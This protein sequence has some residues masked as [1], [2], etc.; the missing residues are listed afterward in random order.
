MLRPRKIKSSLL[1]GG[2]IYG[3]WYQQQ[4]QLLPAPGT[5]C[6]GQAAGAVF[7]P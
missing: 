6:A 4:R 7:G 3:Y 2:P 1:G 5:G